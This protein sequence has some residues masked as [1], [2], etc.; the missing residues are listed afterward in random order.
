MAEASE[1]SID[2]VVRF[3]LERHGDDR[4][5]FVE[6]FRNR[7]FGEFE[8][9]QWNFLRSA[10]DVL[11]GF[12]CHVHHTDLLAMID[13][14]MILGLKDLRTDSPTHDVSLTLVLD[15]TTELVMI[16]PGVGHG[17]YFPEPAM[18][19]YA[20]SHEW[21]TDDEMGCRWD[22]PALGIDWRA[23]DPTIS[24]RDRTAGS[25]DELRRTVA[26]GLALVS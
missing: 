21:C 6:I 1:T 12:H 4:G 3:P 26:A 19:V 13:G 11:R 17:F 24:E 15:P 5:T 18:L 7:W 22:D 14:T 20:V 2:G 23:E 25:L 9:V 8:P 16:P 10:G